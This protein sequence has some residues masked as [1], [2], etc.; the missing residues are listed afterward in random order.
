MELI[1]VMA[2][3]ELMEIMVVNLLVIVVR[4]LGVWGM[5]EWLLMGRMGGDDGG[6]M[7]VCVGRG[8][9]YSV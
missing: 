1:E 5:V 8:L 7:D 3:V 2:I 6:G 9:R 4:H